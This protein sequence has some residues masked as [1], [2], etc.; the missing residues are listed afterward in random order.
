M[1]RGIAFLAVALLYDLPDRQFLCVSW[2]H[3]LLPC[4]SEQVNSH[5]QSGTLWK[6]SNSQGT[7]SD[8]WK[9]VYKGVSGLQA[10]EACDI[11]LQSLKICV[12]TPQRLFI[13]AGTEMSTYT[14]PGHADHVPWGV[15]AAPFQGCAGGQP[16]PSLTSLQGF[17]PSN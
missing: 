3:N 9:L 13:P 10:Q 17:E 12:W 15:A 1:L 7:R 2:F 14:Y 6:S 5:L 16:H 11:C 8:G 4:E